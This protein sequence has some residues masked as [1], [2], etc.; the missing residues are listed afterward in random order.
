MVPVVFLFGCG[1]CLPVFPK[2]TQIA[3][4]TIPHFVSMDFL[5]PQFVECGARVVAGGCIVDHD[6]TLRCF[7][8]RVGC[9]YDMVVVIFFHSFFYIKNCTSLYYTGG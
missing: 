2:I 9:R 4:S 7:F 6:V 3:Y 1:T 5:E 8:S